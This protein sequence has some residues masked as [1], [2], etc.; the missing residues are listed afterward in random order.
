MAD[1]I[2]EIASVRHVTKNHVVIVCSVGYKV[3][4]FNISES[5]QAEAIITADDGSETIRLHLEGPTDTQGIQIDGDD[6]VMHITYVEK[7]SA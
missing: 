2:P 6:R 3:A 7:P 5:R 1:N 4:V